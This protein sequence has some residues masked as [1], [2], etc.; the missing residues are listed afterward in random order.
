VERGLRL[1]AQDLSRSR[2]KT[3]VE[4]VARDLESGVALPDAIDRHRRAFPPL[5]ATVVDAGIRAGN[6][7]AVLFNIGRHLE[8]SQ[9][10]RASL[11]R[12]LAYPVALLLALV[13]LSAFLSAS[14][15]PMM[16]DSLYRADGNSVFSVMMGPRGTAPTPRPIVPWI[17]RLVADVGRFAPT[18]AI[19]CVA[20]V[21]GWSL[22]WPVLRGTAFG[23]RVR[24]DVLAR[25]PLIGPPVR[26]DLVGRWCDAVRVGV[27]AGLDLPRALTLAAEA[28]GSN[29]L[30]SDTGRLIDAHDRGADLASVAGLRMLPA[31]VPA[32]IDL[33]MRSQQLPRS[34]ATL[35]ELYLRQA[36]GRARAIPL[37]LTPILLLLIAAIVGAMLAA[38]FVPLVRM[39]NSIM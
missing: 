29:R 17:T 11:T 30:A 18:L 28:I 2:L 22:A 25:L 10:I 23:A 34:L 14:V 26:F 36:D 7:P 1:V 16:V 9:R 38:I 19:I 31:T 37:V 33:A 4:A 39:L 3:A 15:L 24:D 32:T 13:L 12:A 35:S 6:L 21:V 5:Y 20:I 8:L 27:E